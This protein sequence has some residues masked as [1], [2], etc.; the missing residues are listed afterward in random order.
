MNTKNT[1][2]PQKLKASWVITGGLVAVNLLAGIPNSWA[3]CDDQGGQCML[4]DGSFRNLYD[5]NFDGTTIG[6]NPEQTAIFLSNKSSLYIANGKLGIN[7]P[8]LTE[9][10]A[11]RVKDD[12]T[13]LY[14]DNIIIS[15]WGGI[16]ATDASYIS[17]YGGSI[18]VTDIGVRAEN[19]AY[20]SLG[21]DNLSMSITGDNARAL[22]LSKSSASM[23]NTLLS[24]SGSASHAIEAENFS[25]FT[26]SS[27]NM[28]TFGDH[29]HGI[30]A[31]D[32]SQ[33]S[34]RNNGNITT[35][36]NN[37]IG[38]Y[39]ADYSSL[40]HY[41]YGNESSLI[42]TSGVNSHAIVISGSSTAKLDAE[43]KSSYITTSG[44]GAYGI[45]FDDSTTGA[46]T[47]S[48][49]NSAIL[50]NIDLESFQATAIMAKN[51][52]PNKVEARNNS[53]I[54]GSDRLVEVRNNINDGPTRLSFYANNS[55][56]FGGAAVDD[57]SYLQMHLSNR[58]QWNL[59]HDASA[60]GLS[61]VSVLLLENNGIIHFDSPRNGVYQTLRVGAGNPGQDTVH[62]SAG[63]TYVRLNT[64]LNEG[65]AWDNQLTDRL[66]I[67]G[68]VNGQTTLIINEAPD[69]PGGQTS[70]SGTHLASEGISLVQV[71]GTATAASFIL[72]GGYITMNDLPYT[73]KLYAY[74]PT[75]NNGAADPTQKQ[76]SGNNHW[77][78]RLQSECM[79]ACV[80]VEPSLPPEPEPPQP[81][82]PPPAKQVVPQVANYLVAPTALLHS[83]LQ[84][85]SSL[86]QH[87]ADMRWEITHQVPMDRQEFFL[88]S[89]NGNYHYRNNLAAGQYG[90]NADITYAATQIGGNIYGL[91]A[92]TSVL[93]LGIAGAYG[94]VAFTPQ[95]EGSQK[96]R[97]D[98]WNMA[99][100]L[101]WQ[102]D[103]GAYVDIVVAYGRFDGQVT[104]VARG[105]TAQL[106]GNSVAASIK[107]GMSFALTDPK[108][109][110]Q[111]HVQLSHQ[112]LKFD[113][114]RDV[115]NFDVTL[116]TA[117]QWTAQTGVELAKHFSANQTHQD[118]KVY[119]SLNIV[120]SF[121]D[122]NKAHLG[123]SFD[124][125][126]SGT[127]LKIGAGVQAVLAKRSH[128]Y[129]DVTWQTPVNRTGT[130]GLSLNIGF[131]LDF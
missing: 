77:D 69:S 109:T 23:S 62:Y 67:E 97:M 16:Y 123:D 85:I 117:E 44:M 110:L 8:S 103:L 73:Y 127:Q 83:G 19:N 92:D 20:V 38:V 4:T 59:H 7:P 111:P 122:H 46:S 74:G 22:F 6:P 128:L 121:S 115:D 81:P 52:I 49:V 82:K 100:Y 10:Y 91:E 1:G 61:E 3:G 101:T 89:A 57:K 28:N 24:T 107:S 80:P 124:I 116:G 41:K 25:Q 30:F 66:F 84:D 98:V 14:I 113:S 70:A 48:L 12:N 13:N 26:L 32:N 86:H 51:Q 55:Q 53:I 65:G 50:N 43:D 34:I 90:Y 11:A 95:R 64:W 72:D 87:L 120:R 5:Y 29:S 35:W 45:M 131:R 63:K 96:T 105:R 106:Q 68:N 88:R 93:R 54:K 60:N 15:G 33:I 71:S 9:I 42:N 114:T 47:F 17:V 31:V 21:N 58:A 130:R 99:P 94:N 18:Q 112:A 102:H 56:L 125:G 37:S 36:G 78:Y 40:N 39:L 129:S 2:L 104:T 76:V 126:R 119:G 79:G 108:L 27:G 75:S 118:N